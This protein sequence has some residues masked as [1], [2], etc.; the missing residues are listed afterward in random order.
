MTN[1]EWLHTLSD[2]ES[3]NRVSDSCNICVFR[4]VDCTY[5][6]MSCCEG[7]LRWLNE[8]HNNDSKK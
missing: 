5:P 1:R 8:G 7:I 4:L 3:A 6:N 2:K